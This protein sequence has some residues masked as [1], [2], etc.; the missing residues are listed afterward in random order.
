MY[1]RVSHRFLAAG[2][3]LYLYNDKFLLKESKIFDLFILYSKIAE[4]F[5]FMNQIVKW[6]QTFFVY[7]IEYKGSSILLFITNIMSENSKHI[8]RSYIF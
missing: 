5:L 6:T 4:W 1:I 8:I 7:R 2:R 3:Q